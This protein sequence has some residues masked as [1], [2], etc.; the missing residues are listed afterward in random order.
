AGYRLSDPIGYWNGLGIFS[1]MGVLLAL[2]FAARAHST[3]ARGVAS[4]LRVALA[5]GFLIALVLDP[6]RFQLLAT[7]LVLA[8][9]SAL[10]IWLC[11]RS[12]ALTTIGSSFDEASAQGRSLLLWTAVLSAASGLTGI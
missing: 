10:G 2:G 11:S 9:W 3:V 4:A 1:V 12:P 8:P 7:G 6:R 5:F